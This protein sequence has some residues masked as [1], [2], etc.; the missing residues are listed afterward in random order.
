MKRN[1][2]IHRRPG[3][4]TRESRRAFS[5]YGGYITGFN[6][7][8]SRQAHRAGWRRR[9]AGGPLFHR[10]LCPRQKGRR[11]AQLRFTQIGVPAVITAPRTRLAHPLLAAAEKVSGEVKQ[12]G[13]SAAL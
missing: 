2:P 13:R 6:W 8:S 11:R 4:N 3:K 9:V 10:H 7:N 5:C 12:N 1:I